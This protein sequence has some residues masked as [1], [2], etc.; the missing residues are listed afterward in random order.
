MV[1]EFRSAE[2]KAERFPQFAQELLSLDCDLIITIG[3]EHAARAFRDRRSD[4]PVVFLAIDYDPLEKGI[5]QSLVRPG[6]NMTGVTALQKEIAVKRVE[7]TKEILPAARHFLVLSDPYNA[8][9]LQEVRKAAESKQARLT[10][11]ELAQPPHNYAAA[12]E[13]G[14]RAKVDALILLTSPVFADKRM[15]IFAA[16]ANARLPI[17]GFATPE[18]VFPVGYSANV[19]SMARR[20]AEIGVRI[21]KG[22]KVADIPVEQAQ[23]FDLQVN[24]K[25]AKTLGMKIP[26]S[27]LARATK[28]IE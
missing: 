4:V 3:P 27:V 2:G 24:L 26:Y 25:A 28:L 13:T 19:A 12:L 1:L 9:Q 11:V 6:G 7:I 18:G 17:V 21:L 14:R 16:A 5:V 22:A 8:E 23:E 20:V 15:D 10:V